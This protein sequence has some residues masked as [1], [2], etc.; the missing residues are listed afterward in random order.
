MYV[1][2]VPDVIQN[3]THFLFDGGIKIV[4]IF[5]PEALEPIISNISQDSASPSS[6]AKDRKVE[7]SVEKISIMGYK[8]VIHP[9]ELKLD[10]KVILN[11]VQ[12]RHLGQNYSYAIQ[13][14]EQA[15]TQIGKA[16]KFC[17]CCT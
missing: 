9:R 1:K 8:C 6:W 4:Y 2:N 12:V 13:L 17:R 15:L 11:N 10:N 14:S 5:C 3:G 16:N 7:F